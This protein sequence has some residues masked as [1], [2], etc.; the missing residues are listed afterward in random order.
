MIIVL[1]IPRSFRNVLASTDHVHIAVMIRAS[2]LLSLVLIIVDSSFSSVLFNL[3]VP[4]GNCETG[5]EVILTWNLS[6]NTQ[7]STDTCHTVKPLFLPASG[8]KVP[9]L[10][11]RHLIAV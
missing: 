8:P 6:T 5:L 2:F 3:A 4:A 10:I 1:H 9:L 11:N 7:Y